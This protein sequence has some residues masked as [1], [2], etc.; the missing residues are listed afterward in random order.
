MKNFNRGLIFFTSLFIS[1][2]AVAT[3]DQSIVDR[4][5]FSVSETRNFVSY[6]EKSSS[7][8]VMKT[9]EVP[10][11]FQCP[12]FSNSP[13][14][15]ILTALDG[16]QNS[17]NVFP[18]CGGTD[19]TNDLLSG[20]SEDLRKKNYRSAKHASEGRDSQTRANC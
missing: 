13:Y 15:D 17:I 6:D 4:E 20:S 3:P 12:L 2:V 11:E 7:P 18:K 14:T 9:A 16:L 10:E 1:G 5:D 8:L 19:K